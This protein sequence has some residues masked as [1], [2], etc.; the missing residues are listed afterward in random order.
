[1]R[2]GLWPRLRSRSG[3]V[4]I[5][6]RPIPFQDGNLDLADAMAGRFVDFGDRDSGKPI[7][8]VVWGDSHAK[9]VMPLLDR[10]RKENSIRAAGAVRS[11]L[12][13]LLDYE[14]HFWSETP[15]FNQSTMEYIVSR[16]IKH[17]I[18]IANWSNYIKADQTYDRLKAGFDKTLRYC[19]SKGVR[20]WVMLSVPTYEHDVPRSLAANS[21]FGRNVN[22]AATDFP[23]Y[24]RM[25]SVQRAMFGAGIAAGVSTLDPREYFMGPE[26]RTLVQIDGQSPYS[27][28]NHLT[29]SSSMRLRPLFE[30]FIR[31]LAKSGGA[32]D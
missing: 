32:P 13:P 26:G 25:I 30:P 5:N 14:S 29:E 21:R 15:A 12:I 27:D 11:S 24:E 17:V 6:L 3:R 2:W 28:S 22:R 20:L 31:A 8:L 4:S 19:D 10:L 23:A 9:A 1:M 18:L 7:D 16:R